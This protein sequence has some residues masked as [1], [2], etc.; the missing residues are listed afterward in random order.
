MDYIVASFTLWLVSTHQCF[1]SWP[2]EGTGQHHLNH[3]PSPTTVTMDG[4]LEPNSQ[5]ELV[6]HS[7]VRFLFLCLSSV[8]VST[9]LSSA[10]STC[11]FVS[12]HSCLPLAA[13]CLLDFALPGS[14]FYAPRIL[15]SLTFSGFD[16]TSIYRS[17]VRWDLCF[18]QTTSYGMNFMVPWI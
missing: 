10:H 9:C 2:D 11:T 18:V 4:H 3:V 1:F 17:T 8:H 16:F 7:I 5:M 12:T 6:G 13:K 14:N 15:S